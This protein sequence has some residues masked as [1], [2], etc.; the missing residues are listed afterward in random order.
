VIIKW[1]NKT[2]WGKT[3]S[4]SNNNGPS[5][6]LLPEGG[7]SSKEV[8]GTSLLGDLTALH[9]L[10]DFLNPYIPIEV[11]KYITLLSVINPDLSQARKNAMRLGNNGHKVLINTKNPGSRIVK[12]AQERINERAPHLCEHTHGVDGL[13]N[14][15]F[16]QQMVGG[17]IS[18]EAVIEKGF[19]GIEKVVMV[20]TSTIRFKLEDGRYNAYQVL[21]E[22]GGNIAGILLNRLTYSY[23]A[24]D[25]ME[26]SPYAL[27]P[28]ISALE[29]LVIQKDIFQNIRYMVKKL[30]LL[31]LNVVKV[32]RLQ[33][34]RNESQEKWIARNQ[35]FIK[36]VA[37][38]LSANYY[39]GILVLPDDQELANHSLTGDA[40]GVSDI[41]R[42][43]EEQVFSGLS[44]DPAMAGRSYSTTETYAGVVY[45]T[46][47]AQLGNMR[48]AIKRFMEKVYMLD[49]WLCGIPVD[50]VS[51]QFKA[52]KRLN[53]NS[54]TLADRYHLMNSLDKARSGMVSPDAAA[55]EE[56]YSEFYDIKKL[57]N[58]PVSPASMSGHVTEFDFDRGLGQYVFVRHSI[59]LDRYKG[60][61]D[62]KD[63][64][65]KANKVERKLQEWVTK[66]LT[67]EFPFF[68][69][70]KAREVIDWAVDF[71]RDNLEEISQDSTVFF[72]AI[73]EHL[74]EI[75][76]YKNILKDKG[77]K[78][79]SKKTT[80]DAA[81]Y[82]KEIDLSV[83]GDYKPK[84]EIRFGDGDK[85]AA[86]MHEAVK[87]LYASR[88]LDDKSFG[89]EMR[90]FAE[91]F[92]KKGES[93]QN[94]W[95]EKAEREFI[96]RF[97]A[98]LEGDLHSQMRLIV[99]SHFG[100]IQSYSRVEQLYTG[101]IKKSRIIVAPGCCSEICEPMRDKEFVVSDVRA[102]I[103]K[104]FIN[105][106]T[107]DA[108]LEFIKK[109]TL[110]KEDTDLPIED[111]VASGKG[112][113]K[114]HPHCRCTNQGVIEK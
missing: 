43:I 102:I 110:T 51:L 79:A 3:A 30:G 33:R 66:A 23:I 89:T 21:G 55:Q 44:Q 8:T 101:G 24:T 53:P 98:A 18:A 19:K 48:Q 28:F 111:L 81:R 91:D 58:A 94:G 74:K 85:K 16:N 20:P 109:T 78:E 31:G 52:D 62:R 65:K 113:P 13:F 42:M 100:R 17:P 14:L 99:E 46:L 29:P 54:E 108:A 107:P 105:A 76:A 114:Y 103:Q 72:E 112:F 7:R 45:H 1:G 37:Q 38:G 60:D 9:G 75:P 64:D 40:R 27:P 10:Y 95:T 80:F 73:R 11:L 86:E 84:V 57:E 69:G 34:E 4:R 32:K 63:D 12:A 6:G 5:R 39:K 61:D 22:V 106:D 104:G 2:L 15:L 70:L 83:F 93:V 77:Y 68:E 50:G 67:K 47:L 87:R 36:E 71:A 96:R 90:A 97:G 35:Q 41:V 56:G 59:N 82:F 88:F 26:H 49:L 25:R 92:F